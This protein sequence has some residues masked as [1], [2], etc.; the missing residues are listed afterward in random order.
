[1][2]AVGDGG[3]LIETVSTEGAF[4]QAIDTGVETHLRAV[5]GV[6]EEEIVYVGSYDGNVYAIDAVT[7][8]PT[9]EDPVT[10]GGSVHSSPAIGPDGTIYVG[11]R[12][13]YVYAI[14]PNNGHQK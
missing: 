8:I 6:G 4:Q 3:T 12:D 10:T 9:W 13:S 5:W 14:D 7:G 1:M 11:S 2:Y